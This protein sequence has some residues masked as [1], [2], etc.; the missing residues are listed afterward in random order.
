MWFLLACGRGPRLQLSYVFGYRP[1]VKGGAEREQLWALPGEAL[2]FVYVAG[3]L[4]GLL[5]R[6]A[7]L[8]LIR[9]GD[10]R[11]GVRP[12]RLDCAE[13]AGEELALDRPAALAVGAVAAGHL[14]LRP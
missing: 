9:G 11:V 4:A 13:R 12:G 1:A 8:L 2:Q 14:C 3:H 7:G 5:V 6:L 10:G